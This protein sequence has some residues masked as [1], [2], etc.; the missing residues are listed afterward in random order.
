MDPVAFEIGP[1]SV[2]WYGILITLG[3][4]IGLYLAI[5]ES[6]RQGL[7]PDD[8]ITYLLFAL[9]VA[10]IGL[11]LYYV[12]FR[13]DYFSVYPEQIFAFRQ[14][15]LAIHGGIFAAILVAIIYCRYKNINFWALADVTAPSLILGQA[16]GRWGNFINQEAYGYET[17]L[18]WAIEI[19]GSY[20]HPTFFYE[21]GWNLLVL[22]FLLYY[23]KKFRQGQG[24]IFSLYL[25]LYSFGRFWIEGLRVDSLMLGPLR[26]AQVVSVI[27]IIVGGYY[28]IRNRK[29]KN[30]AVY[31]KR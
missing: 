26:V 5:R 19:N 28:L 6:Q 25:I 13:W 11:R 23:R 24:E 10:V 18:P 20:H 15:G 22:A 31:L 1:I 2:Y 9:P 14:G 27:L 29:E 7:D 16:I 4:L 12:I 8:L 3:I 21:S 17:D 30:Q